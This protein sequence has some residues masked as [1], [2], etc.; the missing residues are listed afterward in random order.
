MNLLAFPTTPLPH[1]SAKHVFTA[2]KVPGDPKGVATLH[3]LL[4]K[5]NMA[6]HKKYLSSQSLNT[7]METT[8]ALF[9]FIC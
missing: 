5:K 6:K 7:H 3:N 9:I 2:G 8:V 4:L 1:F